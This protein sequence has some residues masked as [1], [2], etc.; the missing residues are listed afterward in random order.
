MI[1]DRVYRKDK[2]WT[3]AILDG[4]ESTL[5]KRAGQTNLSVQSLRPAGYSKENFSG[6]QAH[7]LDPARVQALVEESQA[8]LGT[9][10][11]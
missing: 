6:K 9:K 8:L 10:L 7:P 2:G 3:V 11:L 4:S 5:E 1:F